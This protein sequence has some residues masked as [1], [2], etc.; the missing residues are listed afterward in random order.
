MPNGY[1]SR[2]LHIISHTHWDREWYLTFQQFRLKLV[3]LV[4][5]LLA[6]LA[7]ESGFRHFMLDGQTI[8]LEDYLD[9]RPEAEAQIR[10]YVRSGRLLI[11]P[12]YILPDMFLVG[13]EAHIRNLLQGERTARR[14]GPKMQVGYLPDPFGQP[15]Q[16]P[17]ILRGFG[18]HTACAWR[19]LADQPAEFWWQ[20]PDGSRVLMAYLRDSYSNGAGLAIDQ[21]E[22]FTQQLASAQASL[23]AHSAVNDHLIMLGTDHMEP[24][25]DTV[26][27]IQYAN[28]HLPGT[29]VLHSTLPKY[30]QAIEKRLRHLDLPVIHGELRAC[31]RSQLLPGVLS[32][33]MWI[34]QRNQASEGLLECWAEPFSTFVT[35]MTEG[36]TRSGTHLPL[37]GQPTSQLEQPAEVI[38]YAWRLLMENHPH[39]SICGCSIDQ[40]HAEMQPRFDQVDQVGEEITRQSLAAIAARV[41]TQRGEAIAAILVFN[42]CNTTNNGPVSAEL[43]LP[44]EVERFEIRD[45]SGEV[46]PYHIEGR[47]GRQVINLLLDRQGLEEGLAMVHDGLIAGMGVQAMH[48]TRQRDQVEV[49]LSLNEN[50]R[51]DLCAWRT[52]IEQGQVYLEDT[53]ITHFHV[54]ARTTGGSQASFMAIDLPPRGWRTFWIY[55]LPVLPEAAAVKLNPVVRLALPLGMRLA[56]SR[57]G[58]WLVNRMQPA[59]KVRPPYVIENA[60]LRVEA[61]PQDG[62]LTLTDLHNGQVYPGL[63][64]FEDGGEAGDSYNYSPPAHDSFQTAR[65]E[66]VRIQRDPLAQTMELDQVLDVPVALTPD[67][68]SRSQQTVR[69]SL[70]TRACL[71]AGVSRLDLTTTVENTAQDHR[72]R[73]HFPVP[74]K[75]AQ[76]QVDSHFEVLNRSLELPNRSPDWVEEPRPEFPQRLFTSLTDGNRGLLLANRGL[77]EVAVLPT[78][79]GNSEIALTLLRCVGWLSRDDLSTRDGHAGPQKPIPEAQMPGTWTFTYALVPHA[80]DWREAQPLAESFA[81]PLRAVTAPCYRGDLPPNGYIL[82]CTPPEFQITAIKTCEDGQGWLARGVNLKAEPVEVA[83]QPWGRFGRAVRTN[84]AEEALEELTVEA[85]GSVRFEAGGHQVVSV[86]FL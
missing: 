45:Q 17:Q 22:I 55:P 6:R 21:P 84:L 86:R 59:P 53:T 32:S 1:P 47:E 38:R 56:D 46:I 72:L 54:I 29:R 66:A 48:F 65:L 23:V 41:D 61:N 44:P 28:R 26:A 3:H 57:L 25:A 80:G 51:A 71:Y 24:P 49:R 52:G 13:P 82:A 9:I 27:A 11:G 7:A 68:A 37:P 18:I 20:S 4:D 33:R 30:I 70:H 79:E 75:A 35:F 16:I 15:G 39:D 5:G 62:T 58:T 83:L 8:V 64:C 74:F 67:R 2:I 43:N 78:P 69:L 85:D 14:F 31:S 76:A 34:K 77:P 60:F 36:L 42:A 19:G 10:K 73:V 40:V 63:N 50:G 12:W 81:I